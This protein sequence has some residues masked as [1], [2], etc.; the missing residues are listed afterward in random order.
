[1]VETAVPWRGGGSMN[2]N[3][4]HFPAKARA[5]RRVG[6]HLSHLAVTLTINTNP[7]MTG[8]VAA[9]GPACH[10]FQIK[11]SAGLH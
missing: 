6:P 4:N 3:Q 9:G 5:P 7:L 2:Q 8:A 11:F 1:M 10:Q